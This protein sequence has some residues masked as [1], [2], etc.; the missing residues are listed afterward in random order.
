[1]SFQ[2]VGLGLENFLGCQHGIAYPAGSQI[3]F[4]QPAVQIFRVGVGAERQLVFFD[5][6]RGVLWPAIV[7]GH[8][9]VHVRQAEMVI[10]RGP[11]RFLCRRRGA[12]GRGLGGRA[13]WRSRLL[14]RRALGRGSQPRAWDNDRCTSEEGCFANPAGD[15]GLNLDGHGWEFLCPGSVIELTPAV[16]TR[17]R[18]T[19]IFLSYAPCS[20]APAHHLVLRR[21]VTPSKKSR[22]SPICL[23]AKKTAVTFVLLLKCCGQSLASSPSLSLD[24]FSS[25]RAW[26]IRHQNAFST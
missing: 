5:G 3:E 20:L 19:R 12:G 23:R 22:H 9:L 6:A 8:I 13:R 1:M 10:S 26:Q 4:G 21:I 7:G 15:L 25:R 18:G 14:W 17:C 16:Q 2:V 11:V 24:H